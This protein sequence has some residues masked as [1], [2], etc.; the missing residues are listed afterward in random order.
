MVE[1]LILFYLSTFHL[2]KEVVPDLDDFVA[3]VYVA[4]DEVVEV[5]LEPSNDL[6]RLGLQLVNQFLAVDLEQSDE[7]VSP[8]LVVLYTRED[9]QAPSGVVHSEVQD[10]RPDVFVLVDV[11]HGVTAEQSI[12]HL[13]TRVLHRLLPYLNLLGCH[14]EHLVVAEIIQVARVFTNEFNLVS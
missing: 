12:Q 14:E 8:V 10:L 7:L 6:S 2:F 5:G 1:Q 3:I 11:S 9:D 13:Y 4:L